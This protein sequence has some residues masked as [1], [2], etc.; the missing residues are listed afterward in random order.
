MYGDTHQRKLKQ[1]SVEILRWDMS[2]C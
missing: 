2:R 1:K